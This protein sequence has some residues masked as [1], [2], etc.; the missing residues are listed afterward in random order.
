MTIYFFSR[1]LL[2][3]IEAQTHDLFHFKFF[4]NKN[5]IL[6][7]IKLIH[8]SPEKGKHNFI[9]PGRRPHEDFFAQ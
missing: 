8:R 4:E 7:Y 9:L 2:D 5:C 1:L 6:Q 3:M